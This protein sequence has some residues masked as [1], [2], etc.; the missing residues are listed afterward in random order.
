MPRLSES[1]RNQAIGMLRGNVSVAHIARTFNT[2]RKTI[3][4]LR[5]RL[6]ATGTVKDRPRT[7]RPKKT[8][9]GQDRYM[10]TLHLRN[11]FKTASETARQFP[12]PTTVSRWTV[13]RRFK[14]FGIVSR[15]PARKL[16]L[17]PRHQ[18]A[19]LTWAQAH[20]RWA[21]RQWNC[22]IFFR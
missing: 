17:L 11:R 6:A 7:G 19:R 3:H 13:V 8:T 2:S 20:R 15:M 9:H 4:L 5:A 14:K 18:Q 12:G 16:R 10:R 1:D 22:V 21:L